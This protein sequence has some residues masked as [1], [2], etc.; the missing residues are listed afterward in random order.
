MIT[1]LIAAGALL[2]DY[3]LTV[4]VS[5]S[6]AVEQVISALPGIA[7][8]RVELGVLAIVL[9]TIANLRGLR[10]SGNIFAVPTYLFVGSCLL[11]IGV[12]VF[13]IVVQ[14]ESAAVAQPVAGAPDVLQ[15]LGLLLILRAFASGAVA[16]SGAEAVT[17]R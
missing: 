13:R 14:G 1:A 17:H 8:L 2:V 7:V 5:T 16:L 10:E 12:G 9:I 6:S 3:V 11:M 15:P 4:A